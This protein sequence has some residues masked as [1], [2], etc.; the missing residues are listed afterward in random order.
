M[1]TQLY[2]GLFF[3]RISAKRHLKQIKSLLF[4]I[5]FYAVNVNSTKLLFY[6]YGLDG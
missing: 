5:N 3:F 6:G 1:Y 4:S 2:T